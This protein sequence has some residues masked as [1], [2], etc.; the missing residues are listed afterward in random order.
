[1]TPNEKGTRARPLTDPSG[2]HETHV[3]DDSIRIF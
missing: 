3:I 1:V 2:I